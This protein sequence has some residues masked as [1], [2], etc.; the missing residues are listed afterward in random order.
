MNQDTKFMVLY[1]QEGQQL[2]VIF[3]PDVH[4]SV[5]QMLQHYFPKY[6]MHAISEVHDIRNQAGQIFMGC[7]V[8]TIPVPIQ[9]TIEFMVAWETE[10]KTNIQ[11]GSDV[12]AASIKNH[13]NNIR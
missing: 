1:S 2:R 13:I 11:H 9:D 4:D 12:N 5:L 8:L 7:H 6:L 3:T 10:F